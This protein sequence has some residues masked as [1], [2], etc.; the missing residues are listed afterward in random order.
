MG[1]GD[2]KSKFELL[3]LQKQFDQFKQS[4]AKVQKDLDDE[5][6]KLQ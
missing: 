1:A 5:K 2:E 3:K 4:A 6:L